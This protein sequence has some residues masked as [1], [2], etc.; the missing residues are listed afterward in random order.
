MAMAMTFEIL[1][2]IDLRGGRVVRLQQGDFARETVYETDPA[3]VAVEFCEAGARWLHV[4]DLDGARSG[5]AANARVI[6]TIVAA[7]RERAKVEVAGGLRDQASVAAAL[8]AGASRVVV[9]TAALADP[10]FAQRLVEGHGSGRIVVAI[11]VRDGL[12]TG[13]GWIP[14]SGGI[15][16]S[17][18]IERLADAGVETFEVTAIERDG[19]LEGPDLGLYG[20][21]RSLGRGVIIASG[22]VTTVDDLRAIRDAGCAGAIVGRAL[23][24]GRLD[25]RQAIEL[26][27]LDG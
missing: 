9:G 27:G 23:Y 16:A 8:G 13:G 11:D 5:E 2:A 22:G 20:R 14:G 3:T 25:L 10:S 21:L 18:A 17:E 6:A 24:E 19:L 26:I 4:V 1:P 12:A 15:V 7:V